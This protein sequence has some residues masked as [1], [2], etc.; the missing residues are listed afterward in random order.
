MLPDIMET[1]PAGS[2]TNQM[3]HYLQEYNSGYFRQYDHGSILN[4]KKYSSKNPPEYTLENVNPLGDINLFYTENDLF[5]AEKDVHRLIPRLG[6]KVN[7]LRVKLREFN[8]LDVMWARNV[9]E[10][11]YDCVKDKINEYEG[12]EFTGKKCNN[13]RKF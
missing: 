8:H 4:R 3:I 1:H 10:V 9:K 6:G 5:A 2:S 7:K 12:F 13:F 11:I